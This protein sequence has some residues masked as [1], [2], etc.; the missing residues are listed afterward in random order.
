MKIFSG[1]SNLPLT[2]LICERLGVEM[3]KIEHKTF[4]SNEKYC[5][6]EEN[7][8]GSD[9]FL[10]QSGS[11]PSNDNLMELL[12]MIDAAKR[13]SAKRITT[14]LPYAF[15]SRQD[16]KDKSRVPISAK[17]VMDLL[18]SAGTNRILTLDLHSPQIVGF[19]NLPVDQLSFR[20]AL[21][22]AIKDIGINVVVSPDIGSSEAGRRILWR[23]L[24]RIWS[25]FQRK[26]ITKPQLK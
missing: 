20:P 26:E 8:R 15:Y 23:L 12:V 19:T 13:A 25:L 3:G 11:N 2:K 4:P 1:T 24:K 6:Y 14:V 9:I 18:E 16:R 21:V 7:I 10:I 5:R 17:L 22:D